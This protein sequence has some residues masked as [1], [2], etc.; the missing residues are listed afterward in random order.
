MNG[1]ISDF[2]LV[3]PIP[4]MQ[5]FKIN[6]TEE[7]AAFS[8]KVGLPAIELPRAKGAIRKDRRHYSEVLNSEERERIAQDFAREIRAFNYVF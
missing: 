1:K 6:L 8:A 3:V 5:K 2:N 7:L 4:G